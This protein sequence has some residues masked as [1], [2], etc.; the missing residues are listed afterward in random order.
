M[1]R[2]KQE[3]AT[4]AKQI[5]ESFA[6][7]PKGLTTE[8]ASEA[9]TFGLVGHVAQELAELI[10]ELALASESDP[11]DLIATLRADVERLTAERDE[12][13]SLR[14]N[15]A[16]AFGQEFDRLR[17]IARS[18]KLDLQGNIAGLERIAARSG[19]KVVR[20]DD[21][22]IEVLRDDLTEFVGDGLAAEGFLTGW[23]RCTNRAR[24]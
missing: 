16:Q 7:L 12:A 2:T 11:P 9:F 23:E 5:A 17:R 20:L 10:R 4:A 18:H 22:R 8:A 15:D 21:Q 14:K 24:R 3:I 13:R 1:V 19:F 6:H